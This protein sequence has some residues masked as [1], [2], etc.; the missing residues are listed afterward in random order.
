MQLRGYLC[1]GQEG[2]PGETD[3]F[4]NPLLKFSI[5]LT[6]AAAPDAVQ[7][8]RHLISPVFICV[9]KKPNP[10]FVLS[11]PSI[12]PKLPWAFPSSCLLP[13]QGGKNQ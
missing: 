4:E 5:P 8:A 7:P 10:S 6:A 3:G 13:A 9:K 11:S 2:N 1:L 12:L